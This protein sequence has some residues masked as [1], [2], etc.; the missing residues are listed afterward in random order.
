VAFREVR[1][2]DA[3]ALPAADQRAEI[4]DGE[5]DQPHGSLRS[6]V[7]ESCGDDD[8]RGNRRERRVAQDRAEQVRVALAG[9]RIEQEVEQAHEE[10]REA[11]QHAVR[12]ERLGDG[13]RDDEH[14]AHRREH[15][16]ADG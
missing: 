8:R 16:G 9:D 14:R 10:V 15:A 5:R 11:E 2:G 7:E 6:P 13:E 12:V 3:P 1:R 4:V